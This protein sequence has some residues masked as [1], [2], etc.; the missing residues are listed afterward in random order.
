MTASVGSAWYTAPSG[1]DNLSDD[2]YRLWHSVQTAMP[3]GRY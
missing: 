2:G 1:D 3:H